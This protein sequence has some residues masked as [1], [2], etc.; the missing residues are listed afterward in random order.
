M[1][2]CLTLSIIRCGAIQGKNVAPSPTP[3]CSSYRKGSLWVTLDYGRQLYL[4]FYYSSL[5]AQSARAVEYTNCIS[6]WE[7]R[8]PQRVSWIYDTKQSDGEVPV[9]LE[10]WRIWS[11]PSLPLSQV[12]WPEV[13]APDRVLSMGQIELNFI[14]ILAWNKIVFVSISNN[15]V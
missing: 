12:L 8:L 5:I 2:P 13:V 3:S 1:P 10:L 11:T 15:S 9:I 6:E 4:L 7:V 14:I